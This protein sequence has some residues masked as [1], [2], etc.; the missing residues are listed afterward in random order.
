LPILDPS[1][2]PIVYYTPMQETAK[3]IP[4]PFTLTRQLK[5]QFMRRVAIAHINKHFGPEP[6]RVRKSLARDL[7]KREQFI[8]EVRYA[9]KA[10]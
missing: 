6:K 2:K 9:T 8:Q 7:A 1:G 4:R 5:R 3:G 10:W